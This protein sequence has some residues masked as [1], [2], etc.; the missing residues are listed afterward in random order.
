[1]TDRA[2]RMCGPC[3]SI[4]AVRVVS[5][6]SH[7]PFVF[8]S[9]GVSSH[10]HTFLMHL[11]WT[12]SQQLQLLQTRRWQQPSPANGKVRAWGF[13]FLLCGVVS[14]GRCVSPV[15]SVSGTDRAGPGTCLCGEQLACA[16]HTPVLLVKGSLLVDVLLAVEMGWAGET[17]W[18]LIA[19]P[20]RELL[21]LVF[22]SPCF[23][24][25][26][27]SSITTAAPWVV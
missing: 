2:G 10:R 12:I 15:P 4:S 20:V 18:K 7:C 11:R 17:H 27:L 16:F 21:H 13:L 26:V 19:P 9:L 25:P 22:L 23:Y 14:R 1:M 3:K 24:S 5:K 8:H 6:T